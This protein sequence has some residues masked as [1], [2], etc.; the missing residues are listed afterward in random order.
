MNCTLTIVSFCSNG[1]FLFVGTALRLL[2]LRN[3]GSRQKASGSRIESSAAGIWLQHASGL[4]FDSAPARLT[5]DIAARSVTPNRS[6][7]LNFVMLI[8]G[9]RVGEC[10]FIALKL[11]LKIL[12]QESECKVAETDGHIK[13]IEIL[14]IN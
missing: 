14:F 3:A 6:N 4:I 5:A 9:R 7:E 10:N 12:A 13:K 8:Y 11:Q 2:S 1:G